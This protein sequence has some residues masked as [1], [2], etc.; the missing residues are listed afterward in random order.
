MKG[1]Q[2]VQKD[3][4]LISSWFTDCSKRLQMP[5]SFFTDGDTTWFSTT[6]SVSFGVQRMAAQN[7]KNQLWICWVAPSMILLQRMKLLK[8]LCFTLPPFSRVSSASGNR[9]SWEYT[10]LI[11][12]PLECSSFCFIFFAKVR[13]KLCVSAWSFPL[14][15]RSNEFCVFLCVCVCKHC[16]YFSPSVYRI[17]SKN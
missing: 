7:R 4:F 13:K 8:L 12:S 14:S 9:E 16:I 5:T 2:S 6:L 15:A 3:R 1:T 10:K 17:C 11:F